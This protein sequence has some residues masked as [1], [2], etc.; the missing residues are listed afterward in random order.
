[1]LTRFRNPHDPNTEAR[2]EAG[3]MTRSELQ[4]AL[5]EECAA[6][7]ETKRMY[8]DLREAVLAAY[9]EASDDAFEVEGDDDDG[10]DDGDEEE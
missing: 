1:M 5:D 9:E 6:H 8:N 2:K 4:K 3:Q 10:D 7:N